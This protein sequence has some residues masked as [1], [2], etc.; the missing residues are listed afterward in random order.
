[1]ARQIGNYDN[2]YT[3]KE[4]LHRGHTLERSAETAIVDSRYPN[5]AY[6]E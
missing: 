2:E 4:E 3:D 5:F 1:M 6:L